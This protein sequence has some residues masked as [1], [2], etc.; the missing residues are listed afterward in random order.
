MK[1]N[2]KTLRYLEESIPELAEAAVTQ[3]YWRALAAGHSVLKTENGM[4]IEV[5][6][7]GTKRIIKKLAP[8]I[9]VEKGLRLEIK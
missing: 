2:E 4:L 8:P 3:A 7:D 5:H 9:P 1:M 6:P